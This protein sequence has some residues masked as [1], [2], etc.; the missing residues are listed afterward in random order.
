MKI[1]IQTGDIVTR[2]DIKE[3]FQILPTHFSDSLCTFVVYASNNSSPSYYYNSKDKVFG[4]H[5]PKASGL[6][7]TEAKT[8]IAVHLIAALE[9][10]HLP[11]KLSASKLQHFR[12]TWSELCAK[13]T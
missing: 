2:S 13:I 8:D 11:D 9:L 6:N 1:V 4:F 7:K 3:L 10:G 12:E 5:S